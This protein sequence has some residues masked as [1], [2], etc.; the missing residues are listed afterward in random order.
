MN[1]LGHRLSSK[2]SLCVSLLV[3]TGLIAC[4]GGG[5]AGSLQ[6]PPAPDFSFALTP[7]IAYVVA[8][9]T[10]AVS[11]SATAVNGFSSSITVQIAGPPPGVSVSLASITLM[12]GISQQ[13]TLSAL[14][15]TS[16]NN[17]N[18]TFTGTSNSLTHTA[19]LAVFVY[20]SLSNTPPSR[21]RYVRTMPPRSTLPGRI[22][23][24]SYTTPAR[25]VFL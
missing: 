9:S 18:I 16:S 14:A 7:A 24:G 20:G 15:G 4:G 1:K 8:G 23:I 12:P 11:L 25:P 17:G 5:G 19:Q 21:T 13:V 3:L 22:P 2:A 6:N 10:T